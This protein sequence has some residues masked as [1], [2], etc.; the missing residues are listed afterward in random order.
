MTI[1][2][3]TM[4]WVKF[5][6]EIL[7]EA[8]KIEFRVPFTG[9]F[10]AL[11]T[12]VHDDAPPII[13]WDTK[14]KRN[15]VSWYVYYGGSAARQWTLESG[16]YCDV[17]GICMQPSMWYGDFPNQG[18]SVMFIL[19]GAKDTINGSL[20]LFPEILKSEFHEIRSTIEAYSHSRKLKG[21]HEASACG[22]KL[23]KSQK[24]NHVIRVTTSDYITE[25]T[26]D[27]WD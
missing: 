13:A 21:M 5:E 14:K 8:L 4:T 2:G 10:T 6:K 19:N 25:I 11:V 16:K 26:L 12:A 17:T 18:E 1:P 9:N 22:M 3:K 27:R 7:P 20:G 15:P 24:W 23:E